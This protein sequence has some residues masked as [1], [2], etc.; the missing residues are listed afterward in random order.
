MVKKNK[1][2]SWKQRQLEIE[3]FI[4]VMKKHPLS[5]PDMVATSGNRRAV[6]G[7]VVRPDHNKFMVAN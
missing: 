4:R 5:T 2:Y 1:K 7:N 6:S 3:A